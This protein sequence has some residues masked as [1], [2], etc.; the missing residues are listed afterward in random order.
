MAEIEYTRGM[1]VKV[2]LGS[3]HVIYA[4]IKSVDDRVTG[5]KLRIVFGNQSRT[6]DVEQVIEVME[7]S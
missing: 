1:H 7:S 6:V 2:R 3:G 4:E 5:K